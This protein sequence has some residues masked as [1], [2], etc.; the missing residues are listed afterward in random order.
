M[1]DEHNDTSTVEGRA[2]EM[3]KF[4][5]TT[6]DR[7]PVKFR[8]SDGT[9]DV[10]ALT[11]SYIELERRQSGGGKA[12][13]SD[14]VETPDAASVSDGLVDESPSPA[15]D[16][17]DVLSSL[18]E[19]LGTA[20]PATPTLQEVW[21]EASTEIASGGLSE[22]TRHKLMSSGV[23][24]DMIK[25]AEETARVR[26]EQIK[27]KAVEVAGSAQNL[28]ATLD[29]AKANLPLEQRQAMVDG[30]R[31][32]NAEILLQGLVD[33]ARRAGV[34]GEQGSLQVADG[35]P[36]LSDNARIQPFRDPAEMQ[37]VM[38]DPRY[39]TDPD[40]RRMTMKRLAVTRGQDPSMY[41]Q[42]YVT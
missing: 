39:G 16:P 18:D 34:L 22:A 42:G 36:P 5:L 1:S 40:Y 9:I 15:A 28:K 13:A 11:T 38:A 10:D 31:G 21:K 7:V 17:T 30:L 12:P 27:A 29:W 4:A 19:T 23:P 14:P 3:A 20:E 35:G 41:D 32:P 2:A 26:T 6:P 8:R 24:A 37:A 25:A 33:R